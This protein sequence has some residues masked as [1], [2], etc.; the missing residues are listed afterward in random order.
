MNA[1]TFNFKK[2]FFSLCIAG[3]LLF[4]MP[5]SAAADQT[6]K[7]KTY[8]AQLESGSVKTRTD[9]AKRI[10]RSHLTDPSLFDKVEQVLLDGYTQN[11]SN[12][13]HV[14]EMAWMCK[15]LA[16]SG[17]TKY[18]PTLTEVLDKSTNRKLKKYAKQSLEQ[19]Y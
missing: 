9:A 12:R 13:H 17:M 1:T 2:I 14:D 11:M 7:V 6:S 19:L 18:K 10:T 3:I 15:A 16:S 8:I 5:I 4:S